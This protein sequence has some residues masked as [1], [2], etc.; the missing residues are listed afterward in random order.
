MVR[1]YFLY[2]L[3]LE[4]TGQYYI[5][6]TS[7]IAEREKSHRA[8]VRTLMRY[9]KIKVKTDIVLPCHLVMAKALIKG[10]TIRDLNINTRWIMNDLRFVVIR[11]TKDIACIIALEDR[12]LL[13]TKDDPLCLNSNRKSSYRENI[14][15]TNRVILNSESYKKQILL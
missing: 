13:E 3:Y 9:V 5:G 14:F 15:R 4:S 8:C 12:Y 7:N 10:R 2:K 1:K 11:R 6:V